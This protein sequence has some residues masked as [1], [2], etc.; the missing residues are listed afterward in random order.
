MRLASRSTSSS[1]T[2]ASPPRGTRSPKQLPAQDAQ[3]KP[4]AGRLETGP[5]RQNPLFSALACRRADQPPANLQAGGSGRL[6]ISRPH[7][8]P[9]LEHRRATILEHAAN[10][11]RE[12]RELLEVARAASMQR[13]PV[14]L[15]ELGREQLRAD[16]RRVID[17]RGLVRIK[18]R[19]RRRR[20]FGAGWAGRKPPEAVSQ[21]NEKR[22]PRPPRAAT[23]TRR[24]SNP[25]KP[26]G[27]STT[28]SVWRGG[29]ADSRARVGRHLPQRAWC[30]PRIRA[31][32]ACGA[33]GADGALPGDAGVRRPERTRV[34]TRPAR[35]DSPPP[36]ES[37]SG[38]SSSCRSRHIRLQ[39]C[40][41][42]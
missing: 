36:A 28:L 24:R 19:P 34:R 42:S 25:V 30:S 27:R 10:D 7:R 8:L 17:R 16:A 9:Q 4:S 32:I 12:A 2:D 5:E 40:R 23:D 21:P 35:R 33:Y 38:T 26:A 39:T 31:I 3:I 1:G 18:P 15:S 37:R 14:C 22:H 6:P 41:W 29:A 11:H 13:L 20:Q